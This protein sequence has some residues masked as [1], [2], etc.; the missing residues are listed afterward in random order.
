MHLRCDLVV[1]LVIA[2]AMLAVRAICS[3]VKTCIACRID[4][5]GMQ[6]STTPLTAETE[7]RTD[8]TSVDLR[9]A[10]P[11]PWSAATSTLHRR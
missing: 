7:T 5:P 10:T 6:T 11:S 2:L 4:S 3:K 8:K 1:S 9:V